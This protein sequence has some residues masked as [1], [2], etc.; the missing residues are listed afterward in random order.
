MQ[1]ENKEQ[2]MKIT[3]FGCGN[4]GKAL[5]E[6][7]SPHHTLFLY[8]HNYSKIE[9]LEKNGFGKA[10]KKPKEALQQSDIVI[11]A[12]KAQGIGDDTAVINGTDNAKQ[13]LLSLLP[14]IPISRLKKQFPS[15]TIIR[16][17]PNLAL[18]YGEG[19]IG[20]CAEDDVTNEFRDL[21]TRLCKPLGKTYWLPESK[22]DAFT[23]L[24][25]S[26]P[27]FIFAMMESMVDAGI[28]MGFSAKD[29]TELVIQMLRGS[30]TM[31]EKS[32][33]HP[34]ELKWQVA[35]PAGTTISGLNKFEEQ[36]V[37]SGIIK[38]FIAAYERAKE[39][40]T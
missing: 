3:I 23:S 21:C 8:D 22:I 38:T 2:T 32:G 12:I 37:R 7:L 15:N 26:G 40:S 1:R 39:L 30:V 5:A 13:I 34:G 18:T 10:V 29:S 16:M 14:G 4:I 27:A 25:G 36:A 35:S 24:A 33:K 20:L 6:R 9:E 31:V 17:M 19:L 11:L 28:T